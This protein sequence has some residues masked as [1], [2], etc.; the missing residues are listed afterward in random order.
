MREQCS[1]L[2]HLDVPLAGILWQSTHSRQSCPLIHQ[3]GCFRKTGGQRLRHKNVIRSEIPNFYSLAIQF[4]H[5]SGQRP[6]THMALRSCTPSGPGNERGL[7]ALG[8]KY[9][10]GYNLDHITLS[11]ILFCSFLVLRPERRDSSML[12]MC[13][14]LKWTYTPQHRCRT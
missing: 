8:I 4:Q 2:S 5:H 12:S 13:A 10:G 6:A 3:Q 7:E 14:H 1:L 11:L 9:T